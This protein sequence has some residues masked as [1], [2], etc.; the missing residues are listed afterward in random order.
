MNDL[1][2]GSEITIG[3]EIGIES[4][5]VIAIGRGKGIMRIGTESERGGR[6]WRRE[7]FPPLERG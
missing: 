1:T 3:E 6:G 7:W 2:V 5:I 4:E